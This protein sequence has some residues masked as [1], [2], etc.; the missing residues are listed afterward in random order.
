MYENINNTNKGSDWNEA[1][2][3]SRFYIANKQS[4]KTI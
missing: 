2:V 1:V 3:Y 4:L